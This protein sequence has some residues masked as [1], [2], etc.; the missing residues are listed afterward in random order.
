V[1]QR[2]LGLVWLCLST[3]V[4]AVGA[5]VVT[6]KDCC[7]ALSVLSSRSLRPHVSALLFGFV[8][9]CVLYK[10]TFQLTPFVEGTPFLIS[11]HPH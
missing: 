8:C 6:P 10:I 5:S 7:S 2:D 3:T 9:V 1:V 11:Q 4:F